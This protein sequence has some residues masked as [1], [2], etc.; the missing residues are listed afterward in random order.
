MAFAAADPAQPPAAGL[1][2]AMTEELNELYGTGDR[3]GLPVLSPDQLAGPR[4]TYLVGRLDGAAVAGGGVRRL[5]HGVGE[6]KRMFVVP[7]HRGRGIAAALLVALEAAAAG[8]GYSS[9]RLDTGPLQQGAQRL[10]ER[11]GYR[12]VPPYNDNPYASFWGEKQLPVAD[13]GH[14][15]T[16]GATRSVE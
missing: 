13:L 15:P 16:P 11:A 9:V 1:L 12:R 5:G 6:V 7:A 8:L 10:Y 4:G 3:L 14:A 2:A